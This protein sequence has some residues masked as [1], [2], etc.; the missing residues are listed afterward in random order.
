MIIVLSSSTS[1]FS[2]RLHYFLM[3]CSRYDSILSLVPSLYYFVIPVIYLPSVIL[4]QIWE[5]SV[6]LPLIWIGG[7]ARRFQ[8]PVCNQWRYIRAPSLQI[9]LI[10]SS[11]GA[12]I[13]PSLPLIY[14][15][16]FLNLPRS[17]CMSNCL[18]S[19]FY[20][21]SF[22]CRCV[23]FFFSLTF[24]LTFPLTFPLPLSFRYFHA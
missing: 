16:L 22:F 17:V 7:S 1:Y 23:C 13:P 10:S 21:S 20:F 4:H 11:S 18:P 19:S 14:F 15:S 8:S 2:F 5:I 6:H 24:H 9:L 12:H 3:T